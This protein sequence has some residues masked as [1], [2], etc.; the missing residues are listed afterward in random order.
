MVFRAA[1]GQVIKGSG[2]V[3]VGLH[4]LPLLWAVVDEHF[5]SVKGH[6]ELSPRTCLSYSSGCG[7]SMMI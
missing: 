3:F 6:E 4:A 5:R 2:G 1:V 7:K